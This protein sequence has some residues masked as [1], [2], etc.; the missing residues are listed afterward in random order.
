MKELGEW[1]WES[2]ANRWYAKPW[3]WILFKVNVVQ[4]R[5]SGTGLSSKP[6]NFTYLPFNLSILSVLFPFDQF[7]PV[8]SI[9]PFLYFLLVMCFVREL[10][11]T[12]FLS[13]ISFLYEYCPL[14]L[15]TQ[16]FPPPRFWNNLSLK[17]PLFVSFLPCHTSWE[18]SLH[19]L[20][21]LPGQLSTSYPLDS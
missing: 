13:Y 9:F 18:S 7:Q 15:Q 8:F 11:Q 6:Y 14:C 17:V 5:K 20:L 21:A 12:L 4:G 1:L 3:Y 2:R 10:S 19:L 16:V